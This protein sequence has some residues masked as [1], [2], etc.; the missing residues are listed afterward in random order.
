MAAFPAFDIELHFSCLD[1]FQINITHIP[2]RYLA[3]LLQPSRLYIHV[4]I[5]SE[6]I[7]SSP[8]NLFHILTQCVW[9]VPVQNGAHSNI[10]AQS[11]R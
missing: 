7:A 2:V 10:Y 8:T 9:Y 3:P 6:S 5:G 11:E 4:A 1:N